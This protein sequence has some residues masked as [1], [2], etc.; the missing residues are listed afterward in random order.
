MAEK[1]KEE[2]V[3]P[4]KPRFGTKWIIIGVAVIAVVAGGATFGIL[5]YLRSAGTAAASQA[6]TVNV[7][8]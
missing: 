4:L 7:F 8:S 3:T 6:T 1:E 5:K 2:A